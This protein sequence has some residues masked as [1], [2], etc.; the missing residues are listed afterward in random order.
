M[1]DSPISSLRKDLKKRINFGI[2]RS[3]KPIPKWPNVLDR[4][5]TT[6]LRKTHP[7]LVRD[8]RNYVFFFGFFI[9]ICVDISVTA[10][11]GIINGFL[12]AIGRLPFGLST[13]GT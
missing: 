10:H 1:N 5:W 8:I 3:G 11:G 13:G 7:P 9:L 2:Q 4:Y 6:F 12:Q